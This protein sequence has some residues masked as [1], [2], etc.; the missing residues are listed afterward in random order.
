MDRCVRIITAF[1][2]IVATVQAAC[3]NLC[4]LHGSCGVNG[5]R[6]SCINRQEVTSVHIIRYFEYST[7]DIFS[8]LR[9]QNIKTSAR[10][11]MAQTAMSH[12][13]VTTVLKGRVPKERL[14]R[15][16]PFR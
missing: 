6:P 7:I 10:A 2:A 5:E 13:P 12:G 9:I 3:P 4:S 14:G 8:H 1:V 15:A 11:T 16:I